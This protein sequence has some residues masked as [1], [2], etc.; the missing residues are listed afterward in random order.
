MVAAESST[1]HGTMASLR[2]SLH[3]SA[4]R[5]TEMIFMH[6]GCGYLEVSAL[7]G[8]FFFLEGQNDLVMRLLSVITGLVFTMYAQI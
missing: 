5:S 2:V 4:V 6:P 3:F 1:V 7:L 8:M